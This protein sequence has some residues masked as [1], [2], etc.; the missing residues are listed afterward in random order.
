MTE[1]W[2][3]FFEEI[4]NKYYFKS[5]NNFLENEY[6]KKTI[7]PPKENIFYAFDLTPLNEVK[8]VILGQDPY[9][10]P[11]QAMGLAFSVPDGVTLPPSLRNIFKEIEN[12]FNELRF[13]SSGDLTYLAKQ[14]VLLLNPI[15]TVEAHKP[16]SHKIKEY[17][18]LFKDIMNL[19]N[20]LNQPIVF[21]LWGNNAKKYEKLLT[22]ENHLVLKTSHPSPLSAN[23]GGWFD[24][25]VFLKC[26]QFLKSK[27]VEP[28]DW[29]NSK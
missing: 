11:N 5:L 9:P 12:E 20:N 19:L 8:V 21:M 26:N 17:D 1:N 10:N 3:I 4:S 27:G 16:L 25:G 24:S 28:I 18:Y 6:K 15:L 29:L 14:G 7:Y 13:S 2:K 23:Q 22:N